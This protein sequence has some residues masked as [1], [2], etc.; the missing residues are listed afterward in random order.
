MNFPE[1]LILE[2]DGHDNSM[3]N[4]LNKCIIS[5]SFLV[6]IQPAMDYL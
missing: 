2:M 3:I 6:N 5:G 4:A 1:A